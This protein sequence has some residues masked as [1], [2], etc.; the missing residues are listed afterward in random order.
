VVREQLAA[1]DLATKGTAGAVGGEDKTVMTMIAQLR[2]V[3]DEEGLL[4]EEEIVQEVLTMGGAGHET[5]GNTLSWACYLL[6]KHPE[7]QATLVAE[8]R[9]HVTG[10][11]PTYDEAT[12]SL[13][14]TLACVYETLRLYSAWLLRHIDFLAANQNRGR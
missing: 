6:G 10:A 4:T 14:F 7:V 8:L 1:H 2:K 11:V 5:T 12:K 9:A 3:K 13:P